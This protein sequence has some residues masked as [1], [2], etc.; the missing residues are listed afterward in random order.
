MKQELD[1]KTVQNYFFKI[2][3]SSKIRILISLFIFNLQTLQIDFLCPKLIKI[4]FQF[5][6][7]NQRINFC[8]SAIIYFYNLKFFFKM[9]SFI[10]KTVN[11]IS[12]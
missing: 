1:Q 5:L 3:L 10:T 7:R 12:H 4:V 9:R 8:H 2:L 11:N 6:F